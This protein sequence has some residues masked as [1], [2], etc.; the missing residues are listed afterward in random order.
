MNENLNTKSIEKIARNERLAY[1]KTWR[2][3]IKT[4]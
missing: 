1:F 2:K 4:L 3:T